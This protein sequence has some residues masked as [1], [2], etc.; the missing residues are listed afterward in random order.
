MIKRYTNRY[1]TIVLH[2]VLQ[3]NLDKLQRVQNVLAR[4]A[5]D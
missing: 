1:F 5:A 3:T 2:G 4:V